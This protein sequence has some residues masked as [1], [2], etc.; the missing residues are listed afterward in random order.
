M[1]KTKKKIGCNHKFCHNLQF[2]IHIRYYKNSKRILTPLLDGED[3]DNAPSRRFVKS[4]KLLETNDWHV[5]E[6]LPHNSSNN[7]KY[8]NK[9]QN[10]NH[11]LLWF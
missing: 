4:T 8:I 3:F 2:H 10:H 7:L 9:K 11:W 6:S 5:T 1:Y